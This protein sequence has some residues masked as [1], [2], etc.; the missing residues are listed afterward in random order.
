MKNY[1]IA[2]LSV[3]TPSCGGAEVKKGSENEPKKQDYAVQPI[4]VPDESEQKEPDYVVRP[5][6]VPAPKCWREGMT[7]EETLECMMSEESTEDF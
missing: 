1:G 2:L 5:V 3:Y 6:V 7:G 4:V